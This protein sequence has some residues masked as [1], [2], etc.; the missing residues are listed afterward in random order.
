[1]YVHR[2]TSVFK[3]EINFHLFGKKLKNVFYHVSIVP[4]KGQPRYMQI[5]N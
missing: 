1:M 3:E 2:L 5:V 4:S